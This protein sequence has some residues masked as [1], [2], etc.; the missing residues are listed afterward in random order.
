MNVI[1]AN[2]VMS[3][4]ADLNIDFD[5]I[6]S[7]FMIQ[8]T[9]DDANCKIDNSAVHVSDEILE[10]DQNEDLVRR[11]TKACPASRIT[12]PWKKFKTTWRPPLKMPQPEVDPSDRQI[13][14]GS[15]R[16][17]CINELMLQ[18]V[19]CSGP[20]IDY[21]SLTTSGYVLNCLPGKTPLW[22]QI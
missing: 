17:L 7:D 12:L 11:Q 3:N 20:T 16:N 21:M 6:A 10:N 14:L 2:P 18:L 4:A 19:S 8:E 15:A 9:F 13:V 5:E 22:I 1:S